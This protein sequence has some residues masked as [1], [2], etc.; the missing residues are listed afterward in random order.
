MSFRTRLLLV[1]MVT[2]ALS[3][4]LVAWQ[5]S[6]NVG[7][8]FSQLDQ[9]RSQAL[10]S[11]F[12]R[13]F[14]RRG[15]DVKAKV[16]AVAASDVAA[17]M[18]IDLSRP[19]SDPSPYVN[20]ARDLAAQSQLDFLEFLSPDSSIISSAQWPAR[21]GYKDPFVDAKSPPSS[22]AFLTVEETPDAT[23]L[24]IVSTATIRAGSSHIYVVGGRKL[25]SDF[26]KSLT[27]P[28]GMR[29]LMY[30]YS[31]ARFPFAERNV[32]TAGAPQRLERLFPLAERAKREHDTGRSAT[33]SESL[34]WSNDAVDSEIF[35]TIPLTGRHNELLGVLLVGSSQKSQVELARHISAIGFIV[36][37]GGIILG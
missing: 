31:G 4:G 11:Q 27:L 2:V 34:A 7:A 21:F 18:S 23:F 14:A 29:V 12:Q 6:A 5:V 22:S 16:D 8:A 1:I 13:E 33:F 26:L 19:N 20:S 17:R 35:Q 37:G 9:E 36:A 15:T 10:V 3:V 28:S 30:R 24:A 25:D 32:I